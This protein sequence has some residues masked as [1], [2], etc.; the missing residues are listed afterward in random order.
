MDKLTSLALLASASLADFL[1]GQH[2]DLRVEVHAPLNGT[3]AFNNGVPDEAFTTTIRKFGDEVA[4]HISE[5]FPTEEPKLEKWQ[6]GWYEDRL[7]RVA[8]SKSIVNVA[9]RMYHRIRINESGEYEV[10]LTYY[11]GETT[12]VN[13]AVRTISNDCKTKNVILFI[14][15]DYCCPYAGTQV[16]QREVPVPHGY[17]PFPVLDHQMTHSIDT[18][19]TDSANSA[20]ALCSGHKST[21]DQF[22]DSKVKTIVK[23]VTRILGMHWSAATAA[24]LHDA[25]PA[26]LVS[27]ARPRSNYGPTIDQALNSITNYTW[28]EYVGAEVFFG[29]SAEAFLPDRHIDPENLAKM[30]NHPSSEAV[31]TLDV[32]GLKEIAS[33][34]TEIT[35]ELDYDR[36]L[37]DLLELDDILSKTIEQLKKMGILDETQII[38]TAD[39]GHGFDVFGSDDTKYLAAAETDRQKRNAISVYG[40]SGESQYTNPVSGI[41]YNTGPNF[42]MN[43]E[44]RYAMAADM[45][46]RPDHHEDYCVRKDGSRSLIIRTYDENGKK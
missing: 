5:F 2:F 13:W 33:K 12:V 16:S 30:K 29:G 27:H 21:L 19:M 25:T 11:N 3:E 10:I 37:G 24:N 1:P 17:D 22:D 7:A 35:Q 8:E 43:W 44:P 15:D 4:R 46:A 45:V 32:P 23:L 34:A 39:H 14:G 20:S 26:A 41:S 36:A 42:P 38:A 40:Q 18:T 6:F 31:P 28:N 9:F